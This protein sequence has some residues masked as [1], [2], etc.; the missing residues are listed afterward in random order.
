MFQINAPFG[1]R[2]FE[3]AFKRRGRLIEVI[4]VLGFRKKYFNVYTK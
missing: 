1:G 4:T 3:E 2:L